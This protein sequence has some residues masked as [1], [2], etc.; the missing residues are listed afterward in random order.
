MDIKL[1]E[2]GDISLVNGDAQT[3]GIG[4]EDLSQRLR[5]RLNTFQGEWFMDN[6]LGI[7]W[8]NRVMGKNRSKM[9]VDALIQDS[10]LKEP[11]ALQIVS[12]TSSI[13]TDRKFSC[14]FRVR[15]ED[16]A[17]SSAITFVLTP[18]N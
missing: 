12:Y 1:D 2:D 4:A 11:D 15:T 8:W 3:T 6:T 7:D 17:I 16:G 13:S 10:I 14:S 18:T 5:I 9:A